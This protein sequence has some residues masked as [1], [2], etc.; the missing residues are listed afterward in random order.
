M[1]EKCNVNAP[2]DCYLIVI[3]LFIVLTLP[4]IPSCPRNVSK[5]LITP[6]FEE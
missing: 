1:S 2:L 4:Y 6:Y 5:K 3:V